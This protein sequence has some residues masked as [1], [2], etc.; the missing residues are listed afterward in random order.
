MFFPTGQLSPLNKHS[1]SFP[2]FSFLPLC[3]HLSPPPPLFHRVTYLFPF[4]CTHPP[5]APLLLF[6]FSF[7]SFLPLFLFFSLFPRHVRIFYHFSPS[8]CSSFRYRPLRPQVVD[9]LEFVFCRL[10][11]ARR[12]ITRFLSLK[13]KQPDGII[14]RHIRPPSASPHASRGRPG[15]DADLARNQWPGEARCEFRGAG[16]SWTGSSPCS[17]P[18]DMHTDAVDCTRG[19]PSGSSHQMNIVSAPRAIRATSW[20]IRLERGGSNARPCIR[21]CNAC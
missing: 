16:G 15:N 11:L 19:S 3:I 12:V 17:G 6:P 18:T 5:L 8:F 7:F 21:T 20:P 10:S 2:H 4:P 1:L 13:T 9:H 14:D